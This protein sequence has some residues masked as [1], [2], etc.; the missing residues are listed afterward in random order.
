MCV[1]EA[2]AAR[3]ACVG[4]VGPSP[5]LCDGKDNDCD[6]EI[7]DGASCANNRVCADGE[8]VTRCG[9]PG[10]APCPADRMCRDG[11]CRYAA[12]AL[13]PCARG[14]RCDPQRGCVDRCTE[15]AARAAPAARRANA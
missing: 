4:G 15:T 11:L 12:C 10:N 14:F 9:A 8:C 1:Q 5:E 7:D 2:G 13:T 6:G 3:F